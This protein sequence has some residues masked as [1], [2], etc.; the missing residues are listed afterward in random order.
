VTGLIHIDETGS[1]EFHTLN[2]SSPV[3]LNRIPFEQLVPG[4]AALEKLLTRY[5]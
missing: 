1:T 2:K 5:R 3:P 4:R